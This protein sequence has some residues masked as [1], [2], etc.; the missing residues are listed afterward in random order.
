M[1]FDIIS[2]GSATIDIFV[3]SSSLKVKKDKSFSSNKS[4][5]LDYGSKNEIDQS[6]ICSGGGATNSAV[7]FSRLGLKSACLSLLGQDQLSS[8]VINDLKSYSV[9]DKLLIRPDK[10]TTDFSVILVSPDGARSVLVNRG[11]TRL[12]DK[13]IVWSKLK[14]NWFYITSLE[15]NLDLLEQLIG[16]ARENNISI[17]L[18][19]G[20]R[21]IDQ[22]KKLIPLL[23][24][25]NF[26]SLNKKE[27][28]NLTGL[29]ISNSNFYSKLK[30]FGSTHVAVTNG[31]RGAHLLTPDQHL[32]SP[33]ASID[34][35]D[36]TG[37]GD[38]FGATFV[39]ALFYQQ[40]PD[41]A[42]H[43]AIKNSASVVSKLGAKPGLL[44]LKQ[45]K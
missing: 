26:L 14:S 17:A 6:L 32:F 33:V 21:E 9:T 4:L 40:K 38:A 35:V 12:E 37:A 34:P 45:L 39:S 42:L 25:V 8:F 15:G 44:N 30:S 2:I 23:K 43:W 1:K 22:A 13:H 29:K 27:A 18:N 10:E 24:Y 5:S 19:P 7:A 20:S 16:H 36:E 28:Q 41:I 3:K 31:R 11:S